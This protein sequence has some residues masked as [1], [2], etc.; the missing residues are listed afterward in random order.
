MNSQPPQD[1]PVFVLPEKR[2]IRLPE[3][4]RRTGL[5]R[6]TI[7]RM[8]SQGAFPRSKSLGKRIAC[9]DSGEI[10][11]WIRKFHRITD[12]V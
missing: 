4:I 1:Q 11:A 3:V 10:D 9:W 5:S 6:A 2:F 7:Y 12:S 8:M